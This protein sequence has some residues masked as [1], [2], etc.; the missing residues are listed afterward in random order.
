MS[1]P[2]LAL[3]AYKSLYKVPSLEYFVKAAENRNAEVIR[4]I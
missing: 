3:S 2:D 1:L 4:L